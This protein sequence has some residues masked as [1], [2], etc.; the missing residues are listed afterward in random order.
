MISLQKQNVELIYV[1]T[2]ITHYCR[3]TSK[4][5][6]AYPFV[7]HLVMITFLKNFSYAIIKK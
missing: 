2:C 7:F 1:Q 6:L 4:Y 5:C 3:Y